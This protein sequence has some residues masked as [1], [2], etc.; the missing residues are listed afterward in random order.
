[1][2]RKVSPDY[3]VIE[4]QTRLEIQCNTLLRLHITVGTCIRSSESGAGP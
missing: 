4:P 3:A 1:M 2:A